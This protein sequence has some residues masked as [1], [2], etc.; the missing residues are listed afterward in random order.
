MKKKTWNMHVEKIAV[1]SQ[2][3]ASSLLRVHEKEMDL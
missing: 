1:A 3:P 2:R